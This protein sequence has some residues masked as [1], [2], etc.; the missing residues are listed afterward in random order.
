MVKDA[1]PV[2]V[3]VPVIWPVDALR[4]TPAGKDPELTDQVYGAAPPLAL[5]VTAYG[6]FACPDGREE[7]VIERGIGE[8]GVP[9]DDTSPEQPEKSVAT[10]RARNDRNRSTLPPKLLVGRR[11]AG[12]VIDS[13]PQSPTESAGSILQ[14]VI[15]VKR[16]QRTDGV[17][18]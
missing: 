11:F 7:I 13:T 12:T 15:P 6:E 18:A 3:G 10:I 8:A 9:F 14:V 5:R 16:L 17:L 4:L 1:V 2:C